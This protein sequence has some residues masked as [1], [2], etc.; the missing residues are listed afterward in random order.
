M[1][2]KSCAG[3]QPWRVQFFQRVDGVGRPGAAQLDVARAVG[4]VLGCDQRRHRE[5][6]KRRRQRIAAADAADRRTGTSHTSSS[7][8]RVTG[9]LSRVEMAE[10][11]GIERAAQD[12]QALRLASWARAQC[13]AEEVRPLRGLVRTGV[14]RRRARSL[15]RGAASMICHSASSSAGS[16]SPV[17]AEICMKGSPNDVTCACSRSSRSGSSSASSL[18]GDGQLRLGEDLRVEEPQLVANRVEVL[19][20]IPARRARYVDQ[21]HQHLGPLD[22]AQELVARGRAR[23]WRP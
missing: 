4:G 2:K 16:P 11:H 13:R 22:V 12:A 8:Q 20:R 18:G 10:V 3:R 14:G 7:A 23:G 1:M 15:R 6:V 19:D 5:A 17:T 21:V 9:G